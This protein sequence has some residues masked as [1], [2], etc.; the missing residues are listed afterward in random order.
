[1]SAVPTRRSLSTSPRVL[2]AELT[3]SSSWEELQRESPQGGGDGPHGA[4]RSRSRGEG[5][6]VALLVVVPPAS[7][8]ADALGAPQRSRDS[9]PASGRFGSSSDHTWCP[10]CGVQFTGWSLTVLRSC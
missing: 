9:G 8:R 5:P 1:M 4:L 6:G 7:V 2:L 10:H 3:P